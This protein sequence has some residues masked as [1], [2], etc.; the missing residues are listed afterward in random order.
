[1]LGLALDHHK[2]GG[3]ANSWLDNIPFASVARKRS[4]N[5]IKRTLQQFVRI[6]F[7]YQMPEPHTIWQRI[8]V[9]SGF[10]GFM[11]PIERYSSVLQFSTFEHD[12]VRILHDMKREDAIWFGSYRPEDLARMICFGNAYDFVKKH[13]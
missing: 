10:D 5:L 11:Q 12:L 4:L 3:N 13:Y 1:M 7:D 9:G 2:L 6:P 8:A